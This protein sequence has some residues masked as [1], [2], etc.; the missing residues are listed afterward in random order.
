M[1]RWILLLLIACSLGTAH[2]GQACEEKQSS[3]A[4]FVSGMKLAMRKWC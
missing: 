1:N 3:V 2:A 4:T